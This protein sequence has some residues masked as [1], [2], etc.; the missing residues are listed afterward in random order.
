MAVVAHAGGRP[1]NETATMV[2]KASGTDH[3][4][5]WETSSATTPLKGGPNR[6]TA[7][8]PAEL[9]AAFGIEGSRVPRGAG[10]IART[11][12]A[13]L[14]DDPAGDDPRTIEPIY[15]RAPRGLAAQAEGEVRWL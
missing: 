1:R 14:A 13:R 6:V 12:A 8:A 3:G 5:G 11:A 4:A 9:A 2:R 15:L 10:A 7:I